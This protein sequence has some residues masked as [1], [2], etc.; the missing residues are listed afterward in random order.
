MHVALVRPL[1]SQCTVGRLSLLAGASRSLVQ[2][3]GPRGDLT[4]LHMHEPPTSLQECSLAKC[5]TAEPVAQ[6][7]HVLAGHEGKVTSLACLPGQLLLS[8]SED[9]S[10]R[11]WDLKTM[12]Q[13]H[14]SLE[15]L[16]LGIDVSNQGFSLCYRYSDNLRASRMP[17]ACFHNLP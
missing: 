4:E 2:E 15:D 9:R 14:V 10:L 16:L 17:R 5:S 11:V 3:P 6:L 12:K 8:C 7:C 1:K 13:I